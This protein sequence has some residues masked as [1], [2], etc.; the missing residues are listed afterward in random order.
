MLYLT[1]FKTKSCYRLLKQ[2]SN[3]LLLSLCLFFSSLAS[4][5]GNLLIFPKRVVFEGE[6]KSQIITLSN[7]GKDTA[8]YSI[9]FVQIRMNEDGRFENITTPDSG[10]LFADSFLRFYPHSVTLGPNES[11]SVK[12]QLT[13]T[14][15]L[16]PGEYRS[17]LY[18][19]AL[20]KAMPLNVSGADSTSISVHL[21]AIFGIT[22]ASII[23]V[24]E[25]T[26]KVDISNLSF[27]KFEDS[28]PVIKMEFDRTGNMS[29]YGDVVV[30]YISP[31]GKATKV[32]EIQGFAVYTPNI[33]RRCKLELKNSEGVDYSTGE[34]SVIYTTQPDAKSVLLAK[35]TL[36]LQSGTSGASAEKH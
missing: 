3:I 28:I 34:L 15:G 18:F 6:K 13:K 24:G 16:K 29:V 14:S 33:I 26:A 19:R 23:R 30:N 9:S 2:I 11:Q 10:Q 1:L 27:E 4:A 31:K 36:V 5:Q 22:I 8:T 12:I 17:H 25:S 20:P 32:G 21:T 35:Q 7:I